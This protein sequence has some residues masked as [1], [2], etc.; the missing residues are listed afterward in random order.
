[1]SSRICTGVAVFAAVKHAKILAVMLPKRLLLH[2][3]QSISRKSSYQA[4]L[5]FRAAASRRP[6]LVEL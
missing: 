4:H 1:M 3:Y 6:K 5:V 2:S